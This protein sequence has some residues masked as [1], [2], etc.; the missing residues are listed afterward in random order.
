MVKINVVSGF[1]GA[2]KTTL[3][4]KLLTGK[5]REE[6]VIL[7]ENEYGEVGV[8]GSFMKDAGITVTELNSGCICCTLAGDFQ[9]SIDELIDTYH[10]DRILVEPTGVG[11]LSEI[12]AAIN[13]AKERHDDIEVG[14]SATVVDAGKCRMYMKNFGEFFLDQVKTASTIIFSRT[15]NLTPDRVEKSRVLIQEAHPDARIITT[16]WDDMDPDFMLE[17]IE[18][19]KPIE[20]TVELHHHDHDHDEHEEHEHHHDHDHDEHEEHEHHHDHDEHEEHEHHH[21]HDEHEEHEHHHDHEDHDEHEHHHHDHDGH[22]HHHHHHAPGEHDADEV[23]QNIGVETARRYEQDEIRAMVNQ[24]SD[25]EE[26]GRILRAKGILQNAAGDWFQFDYVPGELEV[27]PGSADYT[28]RLCVIGAD[29]N[30]KALREL[31]NV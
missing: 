7:L 23:F 31:F 3:I 13:Q 5:L 1:L 12:L 19:G 28:G 8:D 20:V 9:K 14:G 18:N 30:E 15:Q 4:K 16:P 6:K 11:K 29:I 25:E 2:G 17:V 24:L 10:P 27:R 21:D 26:Y 22:E